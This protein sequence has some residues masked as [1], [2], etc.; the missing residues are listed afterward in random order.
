MSLM[1]PLPGPLN[2]PHPASISPS[3]G[4]ALPDACGTDQGNKSVRLSCT[5]PTAPI[6]FPEE[7]CKGT[8]KL[9]LESYLATLNGSFNKPGDDLRTEEYV[10]RNR[11][12]YI[13]LPNCSCR[14]VGSRR[15]LE[16]PG[17]LFTASTD[18]PV[19]LS[20]DTDYSFRA[21]PI[22]LGA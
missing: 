9:S 16:T 5:N 20:Q 6:G 1:L 18:F 8:P 11:Q 3:L 21:T 14:T 17:A 13:I 10:G 4:L 15:V 19:S 2:T 7:C 22:C 12:I